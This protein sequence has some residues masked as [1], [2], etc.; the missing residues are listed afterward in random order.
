ME[1]FGTEASGNLER[2]YKDIPKEDASGQVMR[3]TE[4]GDAVNQ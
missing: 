4:M 2:E 3:M 1:A